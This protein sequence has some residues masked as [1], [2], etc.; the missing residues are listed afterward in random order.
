MLVLC[1]LVHPQDNELMLKNYNYFQRSCKSRV[2]SVFLF[3]ILNT[4]VR[5]V[6]HL[7]SISHLPVQPSDRQSPMCSEFCPSQI[8][9]T[10][11]PFDLN[12]KNSDIFWTSGLSTITAA[13]ERFYFFLFF[14]VSHSVYITDEKSSP[15]IFS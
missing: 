5:F 4:E 11:P 14:F 10:D 6:E 15:Y 8:T 2:E 13:S 7:V 12:G 9:Y 3:T 1:I